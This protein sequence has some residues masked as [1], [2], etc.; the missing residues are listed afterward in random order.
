MLKQRPD[1]HLSADQLL[2]ALA[3][4]PDLGAD[5]KNH[6]GQCPACRKELERLKQGLGRLGQTARQMAPGTAR[7][8]R[9]P[10]KAAPAAWW[11]FNPMWAT[12]AAGILLVAF[13]VWW[14]RSLT[15]PAQVPTVAVR[16]PDAAASLFDQVDALVDDA[17]P[18]T[19][20]A[21]AAASDLDDADDELDWLVPLVGDDQNDDSWI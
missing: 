18:P 3:D 12:V 5:R 20:Q 14:P 17:L 2:Q 21:L 16:N 11:R 6:L 8:F 7:P 1:D 9:L 13:T 4:L 10:S 19:L 15:P